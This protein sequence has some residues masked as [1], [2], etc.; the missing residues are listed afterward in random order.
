MYE[1]TLS[2]LKEE[3]NERMWFNT[4]VKLAKVNHGSSVMNLTSSQLRFIA[5]HAVSCI[6]DVTAVMAMQ[7]S[8]ASS[9]CK[10]YPETNPKKIYIYPET[11]PTRL[12][13]RSDMQQPYF[14]KKRR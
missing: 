6:V 3:G 13:R 8:C 14:T 11:K 12:K 10:I 1:T 5:H 2:A 7:L 4:Y 9:N